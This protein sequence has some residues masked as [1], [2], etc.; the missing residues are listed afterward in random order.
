VG[1]NERDVS[2]DVFEQSAISERDLPKALHV[3][4]E[5]ETSQ[6]R[7][8]L[9]CLRTE[10]Y[11]VSNAS[12]TVWPTSRASSGLI[13]LPWDRFR[14]LSECSHV[15]STTRRSHIF[16]KWL[17]GSTPRCWARVRSSVRCEPL[18]NC[19]DEHAAGLVLGRCS[20]TRGGRQRV[21]T[22]T[23]IAQGRHLWHTRVALAAG[24]LEA[25]RRPTVLVIGGGNGRGSQG[26]RQRWPGSRRVATAL[27]AGSSCSR[28]VRCGRGEPVKVGRGARDGDIVLTRRPPRGRVGRC[29]RGRTM[30]S[31]QE[32]PLVVDVAVPRDVDRPWPTSKESVCWT[33]RTCGGLR[34]LNVYAPRRDPAVRAVLPRSSSATGPRQPQVS[35]PVV[36]ACGRGPSRFVARAA[37]HSAQLDALGPQARE[38]VEQVTQ[39]TVAK[40]LHEP[41]CGS[42]TLQA[43]RAAKARRGAAQPVRPVERAVLTLRVATRGS[44]LALR[45]AELVRARSPRPVGAI[46]SR[47]VTSLSSSRP[48]AICTGPPSCDRRPGRVCDRS[49]AVLSRARDVAVHSRRICR[50]RRLRELVIVAVPQRA[51]PRDALWARARRSGSGARVATEPR[52]AAQLSWVRPDLRFEE[53]RGNS[54][55]DRKVPEREPSSWPTPRLSASAS[56]RLREFWR[57]DDASTGG[58]GA[59][60]IQSGQ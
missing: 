31:R 8:A 43:R 36:A 6:R 12:T 58:Q 50:P 23:A 32:A 22:E 4:C 30:R 59:L 60:A 51:D 7:C 27:P 10:V 26:A 52:G 49:R 46:A 53:L 2:L 47:I 18:P 25:P 54:Y 45:Q 3:L 56:P 39:R 37:R 29:S 48:P 24:Q 15:G 38:I 21:R 16:S 19:P 17:P 40:L 1:I 57:P 35:R 41:T 44:P 33:S 11:A 28:A 5:S 13:R 55:A 14:V 9:T 20:V 42:R 34:R